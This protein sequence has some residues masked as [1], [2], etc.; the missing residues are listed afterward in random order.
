[1][2]LLF[3]Q[4]INL[5]LK[6]YYLTNIT[7][8]TFKHKEGDSLINNKQIRMLIIEDNFLFS[9][10]LSVL[11]MG[12]LKNQNITPQID[13]AYTKDEGFNFLCSNQYEIVVFDIDLDI[14]GAGLDLLKQFSSKI[15]FP[16]IST[17]RQNKEMV[18]QGYEYG[19]LHF[20]N[21][22]LSEDKIH[23]V[24][25]DYSKSFNQYALQQKIFDKF[26][27]QD[28]EV[29]NE[30]LKILNIDDNSTHINGE[31]GVGKQ[32]VA[33]LIHAIGEGEKST[34][35]EY[36]CPA[37]QGQNMDVKLFGSE[38]GSYTSSNKYRKG[39]FEEASGG[40]LFLD[41]IGK[42]SLEFQAILLKVLETKEVFPFGSSKAV[43]VDFKLVTASSLNIDELLAEGL[44]LK[45]LWNRIS[46]EVIY[47]KPLRER[48][49]DISL[50]IDS[51]M[52]SHK[53][54]RLF[55]IDKE[56][57]QILN[58]YNWSG[59]TREIKSF[60]N[61]QQRN[62]I[63]ILK[64]QHVKVLQNR[65]I[66]KNYKLVNVSIM[67]FAE[68]NGLPEALDQISKEIIQHFHYKN[69]SHIRKTI[70]DLLIT[71]NKFYKHIDKKGEQNDVT[72][73]QA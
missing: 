30:L 21:K 59:N 68:E 26:I 32:V 61:K 15:P 52:K 24:V 7:W 41:E 9:E 56:A 55:S 27:T 2:K 64:S 14:R 63:K 4:F 67:N 28:T 40:T 60:V 34:F 22:P 3:F 11:F 51:F 44:F 37:L 17:S 45:D 23:S 8:L 13:R 16:L 62:K 57:E 6:Y 47:I 58:K 18:K 31:T 35:F 46:E 70:R 50:Q 66:K 25:L 38:E 36:S 20:I 54:G 69:D 29:K 1:M 42:T 12:S 33:E 53:S 19:C 5:F 71:Q 73:L 72:K 10:H 65:I 43:S 49:K 39:I 48:R